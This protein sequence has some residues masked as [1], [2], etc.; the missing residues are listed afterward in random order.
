MGS[1]RLERK[2]FYKNIDMK[3]IVDNI[4][5][6]FSESGFEFLTETKTKNG[7]EICA[8][9]SSCYKIKG[10]VLVNVERE[11]EETSITLELRVDGKDRHIPYPIVG[12]MIFGGGYFLLQEFKA[13][14]AWINLRR[15]FWRYINQIAR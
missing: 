5:R 7:Y 13:Q 14:E 9:G 4:T 1:V 10:L 3:L 12:S 11:K 2:C 15:E 6:F 8:G